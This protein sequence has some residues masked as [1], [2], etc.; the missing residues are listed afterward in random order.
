MAF[1]CSAPIQ[2][3][4][5]DVRRFLKKELNY[6]RRVAIIVCPGMGGNG[7]QDQAY[8]MWGNLNM[9]FDEWITFAN[10]GDEF[11]NYDLKSGRKDHPG[12]KP[13]LK[14]NKVEELKQLIRDRPL[15]ASPVILWGF[16]AGA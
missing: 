15:Y 6:P 12:G 2:W 16:S 14:M 4:A 13:E 1:V 3:N 11:M 8:T 9:W 5:A 10:A 7:H